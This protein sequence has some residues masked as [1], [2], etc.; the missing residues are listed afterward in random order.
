[1]Q[2]QDEAKIQKQEKPKQSLEEMMRSAGIC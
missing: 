2:T 1:M